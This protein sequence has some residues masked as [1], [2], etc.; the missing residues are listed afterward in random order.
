M[1]FQRHGRTVLDQCPLTR[2][3]AAAIGFFST[4]ATGPFVVQV[5]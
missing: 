3:D 5:R 1:S 4:V 2:G